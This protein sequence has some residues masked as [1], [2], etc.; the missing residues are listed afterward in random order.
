[1]T[2][3]FIKPIKMS[4]ISTDMI[5]IFKYISWGLFTPAVTSQATSPQMAFISCSFSFV[6]PQLPS[7][8]ARRTPALL[9]TITL[10]WIHNFFPVYAGPELCDRVQ[11]IPLMIKKKLKCDSGRVS[12][13][14]SA[15]A[16]PDIGKYTWRTKFSLARFLFLLLSF[17][18]SCFLTGELR[19]IGV[20]IV[21]S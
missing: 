6:F 20:L 3:F 12:A 17:S 8:I 10:G 21:I 18:S 4:K 14:P 13:S 11:F 9:W 1:M 19:F 5:G 7:E 2:H 16:L 15:T